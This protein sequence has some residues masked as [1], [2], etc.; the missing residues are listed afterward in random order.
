MSDVRPFHLPGAGA[1][2][3]VRQRVHAAL[4][5]W[6]REWLADDDRLAAT[7]VESATREH[8]R[9]AEDFE[10]LVGAKGRVWFRQGASERASFGRAVLGD[11]LMPRS[12]P[13]DDWVADVAGEAWTL[14]NRALCESLV[15][16]ALA[17]PPADDSSGSM[18]V[19]RAGSGAI[20]IR[21][22]PLG[23][24]A[25]ADAGVWSLTPPTE[26]PA[27]RA[28][29]LVPLER[30]ARQSS[31]RIEVLLG[32]AELP[33]PTIMDLRRGDVLRLSSRLD[34]P[35]AVCCEGRPFAR[36]LLG[37]LDGRRS[38]LISDTHPL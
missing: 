26:R 18:H 3:Q 33:L 22:E 15:G 21:C 27:G 10:G 5:S 17:A 6:A 12:L 20:T 35:L 14:R 11:A 38:I 1:L 37:D 2:A 28:P 23:L 32:S 36:A 4:R 31:L 13:A 9:G 19:M 16:A 7:T 8:V 29:A 34:Q 24:F 25:I 30:A